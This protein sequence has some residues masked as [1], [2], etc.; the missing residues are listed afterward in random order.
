MYALLLF[1]LSC[2]DPDAINYRSYNHILKKG[3]YEMYVPK[4]I[5]P[6]KKINPEAIAAFADPVNQ[7]FLM[8]IREEIPDTEKDSVVIEL[9][10]YYTFAKSAITDE[11]ENAILIKQNNLLI[12]NEIAILAEIEGLYG[13]RK[14]YYCLAVIKTQNYFYQIIGWTKDELKQT[15]GKALYNSCLSFTE[16][17]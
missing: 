9:E 8:V 12:N 14:I 7:T 6:D 17:L 15:H 10:N 5:Y 3:M 13:G 11:L 1:I 16:L 4:Y 2:K